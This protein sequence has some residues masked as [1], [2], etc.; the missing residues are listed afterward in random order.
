MHGAAMDDEGCYWCAVHGAAALHRYDAGGHLISQVALPVS[1]PTMCTFVGA[2]LDEMVITSA[3]EN[4]TEEQLE[5]EPH[6]GG[7]FHLRPGV[8]G[9][10]RPCVVK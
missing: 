4:L 1:Q 9:I 5:R 8:R 10:A 2:D 7:V 6:A 3:R